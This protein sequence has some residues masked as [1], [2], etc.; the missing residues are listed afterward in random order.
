MKILV[1]FTG[2]FIALFIVLL[3]N[4]YVLKFAIPEFL[5]GW[6]SCLG[7]FIARDVYDEANK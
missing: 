5:K 2:A 7:W 4:D 3:L 1:S 6:F